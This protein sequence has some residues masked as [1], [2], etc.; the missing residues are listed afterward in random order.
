VRKQREVAVRAAEKAATAESVL[1][2]AVV[3]IVAS[4]ARRGASAA[5]AKGSRV[6]GGG[7]GGTIEKIKEAGVGVGTLK[8]RLSRKKFLKVN[9]LNYIDIGSFSRL[10]VFKSTD[11]PPL[12]PFF[13]SSLP[14]FISCP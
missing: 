6:A 8:I 4:R 10:L 5:T 9:E 2:S 12:C 3:I 11:P 1:R 13:I 7:S 14:F